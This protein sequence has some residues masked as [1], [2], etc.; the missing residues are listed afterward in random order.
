[1]W[2]RF[3]LNAPHLNID[4]M[5]NIC[6]LSNL[7][8]LLWQSINKSAHFYLC[9]FNLPDHRFH[10]IFS[11]KVVMVDSKYITSHIVIGSSFIIAISSFLLLVLASDIP[12]ILQHIHYLNAF[13]GWLFNVDQSRKAR[14]RALGY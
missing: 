7:S 1:M 6:L 13:Y 14:R 3:A 9:H 11:E 10:F 12:R 8:I 5:N 2:K 4:R